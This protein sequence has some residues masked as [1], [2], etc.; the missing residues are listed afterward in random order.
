MRHG[1]DVVAQA[2]HNI[3]AVE[4]PRADDVA[5]IHHPRHA[6]GVIKRGRL[7]LIIQVDGHIGL[8]GR[9]IQRGLALDPDEN[10]DIQIADQG[11][12]ARK[13]PLRSRAV[14]TRP[15]VNGHPALRQ[16]ASRDVSAELGEVQG[17]AALACLLGQGKTEGVSADDEGVAA[18]AA[19]DN[20]LRGRDR[21]R[22]AAHHR[23]TVAALRRSL[24]RANGP[25]IAE[26]GRRRHFLAIAARRRPGKV[27]RHTRGVAAVVQQGFAALRRAHQIEGLVA[28]LQALAAIG[29][30]EH[31]IDRM[32]GPVI[33][34]INGAVADLVAV[35][36]A[37]DGRDIA[38]DGREIQ[39]IVAVLV[40]RI[41]HPDAVFLLHAL[42]QF[43]G[44]RRGR[45]AVV[46]DKGIVAAIGQQLVM[47]CHG[48][49]GG[50]ARL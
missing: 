14:D 12:R 25:H 7:V 39:R 26:A 31:H 47:R 29:G 13:I 16:H 4:S 40:V 46:K 17:V 3:I 8:I 28:Y 19:F 27:D 35:L 9:V 33:V 30:L 48:R 10:L 21:D 43:N 18:A 23:D 36:I 24:D 37:D 2:A 49:Q 22:G 42:T 50:P 32:L 41:A 6:R 5:D 38:L 11:R 45:G 20:V 34:A 15:H 44:R 1:D